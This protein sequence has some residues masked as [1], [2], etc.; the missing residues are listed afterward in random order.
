MTPEVEQN[1]VSIAHGRAGW[2]RRQVLRGLGAWIALPALESLR[3]ASLLAAG[4]S[5]EQRLAVTATGAPL[6]TAFVYFPNGAIPASWWPKQE[7]SKP[8]LSRT[9]QPLES[10]RGL[11]Q[12]LGGL[13]HHTAEGGPDGP[14][15]HARGNGTFLTGVRLKKSA[16]DLR[17]GISFDQVLAHR[18]GHLTRF[19]SLDSPAR[20]PARAGPAI[21][22]TR[23]RT[24]TTCPGARQPRR[25][26]P[27]PT[28]GSSSNGFLAPVR[29]ASTAP[30]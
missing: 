9:L 24:S 6:R 4:A 15:D 2:N 16:T 18:F 30:I 22:A 23:A 1:H 10:S 11:L 29:T 8:E 19:P 25:Y 12:V 17:A 21:P 3:P 27:S 20:R 14:G 26:R 13:N 28:P 7:G 5:P